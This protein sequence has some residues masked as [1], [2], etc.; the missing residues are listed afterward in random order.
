MGLLS[1]PREIGT[2]P[3]SGKPVTAG[4]GRY[5]PYIK[6]DGAY[7]SLPRD[8]S[9]LTVGLNR[10]VV[11]LAEQPKRGAR[12]IRALGDH[13]TDGK[14]VTL[15]EGRYGPYVEHG[16]LRATLPK[17]ET[18]EHITLER[19]TALLAEKA[20]KG[21]AGGKSPRRRTAAKRTG[22]AK[23]KPA[24]KTAAKTPPSD[25]P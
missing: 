12:T 14:P 7:R 21:G 16:K 22:G 18:P 4:I 1:L 25:T 2:H 3:E 17:D 24:R 8:E 23:R 19:A 10:A 15:R 9:V 13:P 20:A 6:H 11:L 5:G